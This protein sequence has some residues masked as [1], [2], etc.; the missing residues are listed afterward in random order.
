MKK[1]FACPVCGGT[2]LVPHGFYDNIN[3]G[4]PYSTTSTI[5]EKCRSCQNGI[6]WGDDDQEDLNFRF[7]LID[8]TEPHISEIDN[9]LPEIHKLIPSLTKS[10]IQHL[11]WLHSRFYNIYNEWFNPEFLIN[12]LEWMHVIF[13]ETHGESVNVD[14]LIRM[15][16]I[17]E[18]LKKQLT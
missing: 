2:Q 1:P 7:E 3:G 9:I 14:F 15:R 13:V 18:K 11:Q 6:V 12:Y 4:F 8:N 5:P 17:I 16:E 10:D